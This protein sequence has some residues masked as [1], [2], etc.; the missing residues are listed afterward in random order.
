[1]SDEIRKRCAEVADLGTGPISDAMENM[2]LRRSV[3][4]GMQF[5]G[6]DPT[7]TLVGPAFT[8][9]QAPKARSVTHDDNRARH[10]EAVHKLAQPGDVIL[11]DNGGRTDIGMFGENLATRAKNR[12]IAGFIV[13]GAIRDREWIR[14]LGFTTVS[15][16]ASPV[17]SKWELETVEMNEPVVIDSVTICPGDVLYADA[18]GVIVLPQE[19]CLAIFD[20][21]EEIRRGE[22]KNRE[23]LYGA[24]ATS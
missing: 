7:G 10:P 6:P 14:K 20:R 18:D 1:M 23:R 16:G 13:H 11:V 24:N 9:R 21:A 12:G 19:H 2:M 4:T 3:I 17:S 5:I 8:V 15:R 22:E